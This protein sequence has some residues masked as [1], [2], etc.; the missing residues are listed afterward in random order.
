MAETT[1]TQEWYRVCLNTIVRKAVELDSERLRILPMGSRVKVTETK[2]RRVRIC[3]PIEGWCSMQSSNGD[4]ILQLITSD[5]DNTV[6]ATPKME[7]QKEQ[8]QSKAATLE[9]QMDGEKGDAEQMEKLKRE[10]EQ[11]KKQLDAANANINA[12][13]ARMKDLFEAEQETKQANV[14]KNL[15]DGDVV[16]MNSGLGLAIVRYVGIPKGASELMVGVELST[17]TINGIKVGDNDGSSDGERYFN[18]KEDHGRF[19]SAA[20]IKKVMTAEMMLSK[21][22]K[23]VQVEATQNTGVNAE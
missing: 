10:Y 20:D 7:S 18:V 9:K 11:V 5:S 13:E 16:M 4:T 8:L 12:Y 6:S 14:L 1:V 19:L 21:L 2:G 17:S 22:M 15:R 23:I 3:Q